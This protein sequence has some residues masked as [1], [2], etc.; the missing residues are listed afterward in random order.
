MDHFGFGHAVIACH[1]IATQSARRT[2]RTASIV[3]S[4]KEGDRVVFTNINEANRVQRLCRERG[5]EIDRIVC[6][7]SHLDRLF[8][9]GPRPRE[10]TRTIFDHTWIEQFYLNAITNAAADIDDMQRKLTGESVENLTTE[11]AFNAH[12]KWTA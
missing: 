3:D 1:R 5:F 8:Q 2:G 10:N 12:A 4:L 9:H 7:P 6:E 11:T